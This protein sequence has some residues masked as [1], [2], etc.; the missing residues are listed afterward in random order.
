MGPAI[1]L[2][3]DDNPDNLFAL[4]QL[5]AAEMP[6]AEIVTAAAADEAVRLAREKPIDLAQIGRASCRERVYTVV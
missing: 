2:L 4:G 3:V 1:F 6:D 5:I